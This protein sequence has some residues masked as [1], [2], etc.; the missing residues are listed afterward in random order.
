M[1]ILE[2]CAN[3]RNIAAPVNKLQSRLPSHNLTEFYILNHPNS[4]YNYTITITQWRRK[5]H[6]PIHNEIAKHSWLCRAFSNADLTV[7][8]CHDV[9]QHLRKV[10]SW[11]II[12]TTRSD[13]FLTK[14]H[15]SSNNHNHNNNSGRKRQNTN[16]TMLRWW[17]NYTNGQKSWEPIC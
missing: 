10:I 12:V 16:S 7:S 5:R 17:C 2:Q 1:T 13:C 15:H 11:S 14:K 6:D 3:N 8:N 4:Y 9:M